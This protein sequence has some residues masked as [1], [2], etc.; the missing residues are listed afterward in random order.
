MSPPE[1]DG[2]DDLRRGE[3]LLAELER[4]I[5][6]AGDFGTPRDDL[7]RARDLLLRALALLRAEPRQPR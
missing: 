2:P 1:P 6:L 7:E 3:A 5:R 4:R